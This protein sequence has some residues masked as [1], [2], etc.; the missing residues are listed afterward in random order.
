[1]SRKTPWVFVDCEARGTS[2][3]NGVLTEF[4]AVHYDSRDTF[5]GRLFDAVPDPENPAIPVVGERVASDADVAASFLAWLAEHLDGRRPVFVSDNPAYD[6]Q[7]IAGLFDR[8]G[9]DNPFGH[10]GRRI[11]DFWAGLNHDWSETQGWKRLRRTVH[12][13]N[14]VND[15]MGNVEAFEEILRMAKDVLAVP[16]LLLAVGDKAQVIVVEQVHVSALGANE[17]RGVSLDPAGERRGRG[18]TDRLGEEPVGAADRTDEAEAANGHVYRL[19][20]FHRPFLAIASYSY[21]SSS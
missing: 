16:A 13:H 19:V 9:T 18:E 15:A 1:M 7:W 20:F 14:P 3:V 11:G 6:W 21:E 10:S 2:P 8:A 4:G 5:H 12:D 17:P